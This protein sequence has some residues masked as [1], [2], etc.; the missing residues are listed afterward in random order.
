MKTMLVILG[1]VVAGCGGKDSGP[2]CEDL[3]GDGVT[4]CDGDCDDDNPLAVPNSNELCGDS[5]DNNCDGVSDENCPPGVGTFVSAIIGDDANGGTIDLP[6]R[7][8][9]AGVATA[10][11]IGG[12]QT[13]IV[14][15]GSY[16]EKVTLVEGVDLQGGYACDATTCTWARDTVVFESLI[17]NQD[18]EGVFA[19]AGITRATLLEGFAITG[20]DGDPQAP[21]GSAGIVIDGGSPTIR[22]NRVTGGNVTGGPFAADR[23]VG[24]ALRS[25]TD[26]AGPLIEGNELSG[27][28]AT[29]LAAGMTIES[30]PVQAKAVATITGN[31][32]RGGTGQRS[33]GI[34][35]FNSAAGTLVTDNDISSGDSTNGVSHGIEVGSTMTIDGNRINIDASRV[36][37][38]INSRTWCS[39]IF[40]E[41]STT[42]ITNNIVVG[43]R[44]QRSAAV[45]LGE[46]EVA[47]GAIVLNGN[48]LIGGGGGS[49]S[50]GSLSESAALVVSIGDCTSCGFNGFVG[51]VRNNILDAG[52]NAVRFGIRE[53]PAPGRVMRPELIE[54]NLF[55]F[56]ASAMPRT[57]IMYRQVRGN[58]P[59]D[60]TTIAMVN[61]QQS[62]PAANNITG[63]PMLDASWHL[64]AGSPCANTGTATE[65]PT[66]D[67]EGEARPTGGGVDIGHDEMP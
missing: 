15:Q 33:V 25:T 18:F 32:I 64:L 44:G 30:F 31:T 1:F 42:T 51:R 7:T 47:G 66:L 4:T 6:K 35:A 48:T 65:A 21:P 34:V 2:G 22:G 62:P 67:F 63:D 61:A 14:G 41:S 52:D 28:T 11:S 49:V 20:L 24:L 26:P 23:S 13:V 40:S 27:G 37:T 56:F 36:G 39:G 3:D 29:N 54:N 58:G 19:G 8:I 59:R 46:F 10:V 50:A 53:D 43:S 9:A 55:F 12:D 5:A 45:F 16:P 57:D 60:L 38:C 17:E